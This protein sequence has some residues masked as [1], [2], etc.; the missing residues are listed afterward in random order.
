MWPISVS[1]MYIP[2]RKT[3]IGH[4]ILFVAG[5]GNQ[6]RLCSK[7]LNALLK[8][9][10]FR[11]KHPPFTPV[12]RSPREIPAALSTGLDDLRV[13]TT[14][15]DVRDA[16]LLGPL[17]AAADV[18]ISAVNYWF[19]VDLAALAVENRAHFLD[20]G[21][22]NDIVARGV[23]TG[24]VGGLSANPLPPMNYKVVIREGR[25]QT[26]PSPSELEHLTFPAPFGELEAFQTSGGTVCRPT[27]SPIAP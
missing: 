12:F 9:V 1:D 21:G 4:T 3:W 19:N 2:P 7:Q 10:S 25:L 13:K 20:R 17:M 8:F 26:V 5:I 16:P 14:C 22:N 24:R 18:A 11:Q 27:S 23:R 15:G 6:L